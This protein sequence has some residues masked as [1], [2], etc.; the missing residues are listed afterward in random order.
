M[1]FMK[2]GLCRATELLKGAASVKVI[3]HIDADGLSAG[4]IMAQ[5]LERQDK[6]FEVVA[7][8]GVYPE[9]ASELDGADLTIFTDIGSGQL[10]ILEPYFKNRDTIILDHHQ[11]QGEPWQGLAHVNPWLEGRD[12]SFEI[13]GAGVAYLFAKRGL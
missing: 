9:N 10:E 13:S 1:D 6:D 3:T 2:R 7:M 11:I 5:M 8:P 4:G 12:G